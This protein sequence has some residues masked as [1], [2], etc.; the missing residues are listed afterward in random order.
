MKYNLLAA[1]AAAA[2]V[3]SGALAQ[4]QENPRKDEK[5]AVEKSETR[6][7]AAPMAEKGEAP[8]AAQMEKTE[9]RAAQAEPRKEGAETKPSAQS[10]Q[11]PDTAA[12]QPTETTKQTAEKRPA[13][14]NMAPKRMA[15][16]SSAQEKKSTERAENGAEQPAKRAQAEAEPQ[17]PEA[18][19]GAAETRGQPKVVGTAEKSP[20]HA[21][22]V[23]E[24]L[25]KNARSENVNIDI[26]VGVRVPESVT[27][28]PMP[29]EVLAFAPEYRGDDYFIAND[30]VVF[31]APDSHEIVGAI[32]YEGR[33]AAEEDS[34]RVA[35]ARPCP[36]EN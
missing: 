12:K 14:E 9:P 32:E 34:T 4:A 20:E 35:G 23:S 2:L 15:E 28:Y 6:P 10:E 13:T 22:R 24:I 26:N 18:R 36:V 21:T 33:A 31:V 8:R 29:E 5:P 17:K 27:V 30:Q 19:S 11:R 7:A 25:M 1:V 16:P 3:A